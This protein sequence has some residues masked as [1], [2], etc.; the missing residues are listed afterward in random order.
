MSNYQDLVGFII[1]HIGGKE[2]IENLT[3]CV[4]RLRFKLKD[5]SLV[6]AGAL[7]K[8][9][10]IVR[11]Q[12][13]GGRFQIVIGT[14]VGDV[15]DEV[16]AQLGMTEVSEVEEKQT[17]LNRI[18]AVI[19][20]TMTPILGVLGGGGIIV[21]IGT[22]LNVL[23]VID[24]SSGAMIVFTA[25]GRATLTFFPVLLGY[26]SAKAFKMNPYVGATIG[27]ALIY[28]NIAV[29][30]TTGEA[31]Y[32]LFRGTV[33]E[34]PIIKTFLGIPIMFPSNGYAST[35]VPIIFINFMASKVER[36]F[37]K[38]L[39]SAIEKS[40]T[41][42][43]TLLVGGVLGIL[44]VG[45]IANILGMAI[46]SMFQSLFDFSPIIAAIA[47]AICWQPL[48]VMGLHW[49]LATIG[50]MEIA[51]YG[52][53]MVNSLIYPC[54]FAQLACCAA[55]YIRTRSNEVKNRAIPGMI[56]S[57]FNIIEPSLYGIVM[58]VKKRI[59]ITIVSY[60]AG[61]IILAVTNT[62]KFTAPP[63]GFIGIVTFINPETGSV[64]N[65]MIAIAAVAV[66]A[67]MSFVLTFFTYKSSDD[68]KIGGVVASQQ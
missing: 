34:F 67:A 8:R 25:L 41:P 47:F 19:T 54:A 66:T 39:P 9:T 20:Q 26:T 42:F 68:E 43:F 51:T 65:M 15:Y 64:R 62:Y 21:G 52:Y 27:A 4:T 11:T 24:A 63:F 13:A 60:M 48:V 32:T 61:C 12:F 23:G 44:I 17:L 56:S 10:G 45:P 7:D 59:G 53:S 46:S 55:V 49:P 3:H 2:N 14:Q 1:E 5:E 58:P 6:D 36:F 33:L 40:L 50:F 16:M 35:V 30:L 22:V 28:P 18:L 38:V 37:K 31:L 57:S 29:D